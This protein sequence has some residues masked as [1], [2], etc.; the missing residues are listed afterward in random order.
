MEV[1]FESCATCFFTEVDMVRLGYR[2]WLWSGK[3]PV[4]LFMSESQ[5]WPPSKYCPSAWTQGI[6][7]GLPPLFLDWYSL[8]VKIYEY[9]DST[10]WYTVL[11]VG[12]GGLIVFMPLFCI[13]FWKI[14]M[15]LR[16]WGSLVLTLFKKH[17]YYLAITHSWDLTQYGV[18]LYVMGNIFPIIYSNSTFSVDVDSISKYSVYICVINLSPLIALKPTY[19]CRPIFR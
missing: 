7:H 5:K 18:L 19:K 14:R 9:I 6:T 10:L 13:A 3:G 15:Y 2:K 16:N 4:G 11:L 17:L 8:R 1:N 12:L